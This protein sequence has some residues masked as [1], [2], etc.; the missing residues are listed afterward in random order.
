[1]TTVKRAMVDL[2]IGCGA[3]DL[4]QLQEGVKLQA[5]YPKNADLEALV[6]ALLTDV[7]FRVEHFPADGT[8]PAATYYG[9]RNFN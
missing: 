4:K 3:Q 9:Y 6:K 2:M 7:D 1:M 5:T 8:L